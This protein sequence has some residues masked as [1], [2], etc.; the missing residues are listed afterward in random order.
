MK[1]ACVVQLHCLLQRQVH[2]RL[3]TVSPRAGRAREALWCATETLHAALKGQKLTHKDLTALAAGVI[4]PSTVTRALNDA[5]NA[6]WVARRAAADDGR[7][8]LLEPTAAARAEWM[9]W[10]M[11]CFAELA[12]VLERSQAE[13]GAPRPPA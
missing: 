8:V 12:E 4:S 1:T 6:G 5:E 9:A 7:S 13:L 2:L 10:A 11:S 3:S